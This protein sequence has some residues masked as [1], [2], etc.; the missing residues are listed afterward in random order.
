VIDWTAII[1]VTSRQVPCLV[2]PGGV[3]DHA[4]SLVSLFVLI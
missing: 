4:T 3:I 2:Q 1:V